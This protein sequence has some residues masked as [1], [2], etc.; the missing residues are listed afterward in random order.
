MTANRGEFLLRVA[1]PSCAYGPVTALRE[2]SLEVWPDEVMCVLRVNGAGKTSLLSTIAG[3]APAAGGRVLVDGEDV[4]GLSP[5]EMVRHRIEL[6]PEGRQ[7][8]VTLTARHTHGGGKPGPGRVSFPEV[9]PVG[10]GR[11]RGDLRDPPRPRL[12]PEPAGG[13]AEASSRCWRSAGP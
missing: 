13:S 3:A 5:E 11:E 10:P 9:P 7:I 8:S 1:G 12:V 6:V 2:V 4:A